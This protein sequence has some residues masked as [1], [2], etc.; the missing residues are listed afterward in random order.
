[1]NR[2][3]LNFCVYIRVVCMYIYLRGGLLLWV[4]VE[5]QHNACRRSTET[6]RFSLKPA[7]SSITIFIIFKDCLKYNK[8][9][10][11]N[12]YRGVSLDVDG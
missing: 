12:N 7:Q 6:A 11:D 4:C 5:K 9:C 1:M 3:S 8:R 2:F 10:F